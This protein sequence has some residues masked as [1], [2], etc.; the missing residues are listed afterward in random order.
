MGPTLEGF[1]RGEWLELRKQARP[2]SWKGD[3]SWLDHYLLPEFGARPLKWLATDEGNRAIFR[4]VVGL[5]SRLAQR[6]GKPLAPRTVWNI[7]SVARVLLADAVDLNYLDRARNPLATF[8]AGK[9]LPEKQDKNATWRETAFFE[10]DQVAALTTDVRLQPH[11]RVWNTL[12]FMVGGARTGEIANLR[13]SDWTESYKGGLGRM[14]ITSSFNTRAQLEKGTKTGA[15]KLIPV[16]PHAARL[17]A[18]WRD[19]GW[20]EWIGRDPR[21]QDFIVARPDGRQFGN[22]HL[23]KH[24]HADLDTL[25]IARRRQY[26]NRSTFRSLLIGAGA[27][28]FIVNRMT[29]PSPKQAS[30]YYNRLELQWPRICEAVLLLDHPAWRLPAKTVHASAPPSRAAPVVDLDQMREWRGVRDSNGCPDERDATRSPAAAPAASAT[31]AAQ[32]REG[33]SDR[34]GSFVLADLRARAARIAQI[35]EAAG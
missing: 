25:G 29:H 23:L 7:Y 33:Q 21:P 28:E 9:Y 22:S 30:D 19:G 31:D 15:K 14:H 34:V 35:G 6:D 1:A 12:A 10:L 2:F 32:A 3:L 20:R 24:F 16:H 26:D 27:D 17:L 18:R 11:R 13:W 8:P 5:K 4:W